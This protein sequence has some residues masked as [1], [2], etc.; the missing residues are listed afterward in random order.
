MK[1]VP[2]SLWIGGVLV[3]MS[4]TA[5]LIALSDQYWWTVIVSAAFAAGAP[6]FLV[7]TIIF[8]TRDIRWTA[9]VCLGIAIVVMYDIYARS[10]RPS[11][12]QPM[13]MW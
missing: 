9:V 12:T 4:V 10:L 3:L 6:F 13:R 5:D 2:R 8:S 7:R 1:D 11:L